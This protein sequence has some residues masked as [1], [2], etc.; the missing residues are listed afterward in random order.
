MAGVAADAPA[1]G[2]CL[3]TGRRDQVYP[4]AALDAHVSL[5]L[6]G[7][8]GDVRLADAAALGQSHHVLVQGRLDRGHLQAVEDGGDMSICSRKMVQ[9]IG[10]LLTEE[11]LWR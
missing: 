11:P 7:G 8:D 6:G 3:S 5:R 4:A 2:A 10:F 9:I 1:R